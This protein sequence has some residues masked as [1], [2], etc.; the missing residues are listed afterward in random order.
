MRDIGLQQLMKWQ[1][2]GFMVLLVT[3]SIV[4]GQDRPPTA[5]EYSC[6]VANIVGIETN[7]Q[8][9]K[10]RFA[11]K[12]E[13]AEKQQKFF[14]TI[15]ELA[16]NEGVSEKWCFSARALDDLRKHRRGEK[17]TYFSSSFMYYA[18]CQARFALSTSGGP[19]T[20]VY[21]AADSPNLFRDEFSQFW[22]T[23]NLFYTWQFLEPSK[24]NAFVAEGKCEKINLGLGVQ[25]P[26]TGYC[27]QPS[28][29]P[30]ASP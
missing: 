18:A 23:N 3:P 25:A 13:L 16:E 1:M 2:A 19:M 24:R 15:A 8:A 5:G 26:A 28:A 20:G 14:V 6:Y 30:L 21:Y 9:R 12:L 4:F 7:Q 27:A 10:K 22:L 17:E 11:G 29:T